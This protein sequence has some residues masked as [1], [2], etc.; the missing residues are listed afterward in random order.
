ML[1]QLGNNN[2]TSF[3]TPISYGPGE[4]GTAFDFS[5]E[6]EV[7]VGP[8]TNLQ[9]QNFTIEGWVSAPPIESRAG[10]STLFGFGEDGYQFGMYQQGT[11]YLAINLENDY[12]GPQNQVD[13]TNAITDTNFH[14]FA[15]TKSGSN[16][17][18][19]IDGIG[20][21]ATILPGTF[22][23]S[24]DA[25]IGATGDGYEPFEGK[26]D[27][28]SVY[29][30]ALSSAE[31]QAIYNAGSEGKCL[32]LT[33]PYIYLQPTN[34]TV[35]AGNT[36]TFTVIATAAQPLFYQW[37]F[38]GTN[39][40]EETNAT[41]LITNAQPSEGGT[42]RVIVSN[43][44]DV[45]PSSNAV[46]IVDLIPDILSQPTN[47]AVRAYYPA[48]LSVEAVGPLPLLY[49]WTFNGTN[50]DDATN[51]ALSFSA[52]L[53]G[54]AGT[55][56]VIVGT[57]PNTTNSSNAVLTV[58]LL[59]LP[60]IL[61]Q[62]ASHIGVAEDYTT[63]NV[64]AQSQ[65]PVPTYYQWS[66]NG[67]NLTD[68]TNSGLVISNLTLG[69][70][71]TYA[72]L[73]SNPFYSTNSQPAILTMIPAPTGTNR[74][75][76]N[77]DPN[78]LSR[79]ILAGGSVTFVCDG[80]FDLSQPIVPLQNVVV[81]GSNHT[82]SFSGGGTSQMLAIPPGVNV[83][84]RNLTLSDGVTNQGGAISNGGV[85]TASNVNIV[86][87]RVIEMGGAIF[88]LGTVTLTSV[89]FSNNTAS[90]QWP[91]FT[92]GGPYEGGGEGFGGAL[93][94]SNGTVNLT[95][96]IFS[97]NTAQGSVW[98]SSAYGGG[99]FNEG[100]AINLQNV[101]FND[102]VAQGGS[103][104]SQ[105]CVQGWGYGG[106]LYS[107]GGWINGNAIECTNNAALSGDGMPES[108]Y[109]FGAI[110]TPGAGQGGA[111]YLANCVAVLSDDS[112]VSNS[113]NC[114]AAYNEPPVS[115]EG[116]ALF[117]SGWTVLEGVEFV[118]NYCVGAT[119]APGWALGDAPDLGIGGGPGGGGIGGAVYNIGLLVMTNCTFA[120]N[121]VSGSD[122]GPGSLCFEC[123]PQFTGPAGAPGN[124][125]GGA[126][127][128]FGMATIVDNVFLNN[129][130]TG[131]GMDVEPI[132]GNIPGQLAPYLAVVQ[133]SQT[134]AAGS[135]VTL[136]ALAWGW[137]DPAYQWSW[138]GTNVASATTTTL[139][140][141]N[142]QLDQAGTYW[143]EV[144]S[145]TGSETSG[146]VDLTVTAPLITLTP[147]NLGS[148]GFS[149]S[150]TGTGAISLVIEVSTN[151]VDWLPVQTNL[152]PFTFV[153]TNAPTSPYRF[154]RA[155]LAH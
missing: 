3:G 74:I 43:S 115:S 133:Q 33:S 76:A 59:P 112:F 93:C 118:G 145:S 46:L 109:G 39:M 87:N 47:E 100:G 55:Y 48:S 141:T 75:V 96:V 90:P 38:D 34:V 125:L 8:A 98:G 19:F 136:N 152:S 140:L 122:G 155:I 149:V 49:Q 153:D 69:N 21:P 126:L 143:V 9:L 65:A 130:A 113:A 95:N 105:D 45:L 103:A 150:A 70:A 71:G 42:Y 97:G 41:L 121:A 20:E 86:G 132:Y 4:V 40:P 81:D 147:G 52:A 80:I 151:L 94:N 117:N 12:D 108:G 37:V 7:D 18:F 127:A 114:S 54:N 104:S 139:V 144:M 129:S 50:I 66:W 119:G 120:R 6:T 27:E 2:G 123:N 154:Y 24:T 88:N 22:H 61:T 101:S 26:I 134:V 11:L 116:G 64:V 30:R 99:V 146:P 57:A 124:A 106:A 135:T 89:M 84:L 82:V 68:A 63:F 128:N 79:A 23:Y 77:L 91:Y 32:S 111:F 28:L 56:A 44:Y 138:D 142:I 137:T 10:T 5:G 131:P 85:L 92:G 62:P 31:I 110:G 60:T 51:S 35:F 73:V 16:V 67:G 17:C 107:F 102:N 14:H 15:A 58:N 36:A 1:D 13:S 78:E 29:D 25:G 72:V 148:T 53:P 83:T